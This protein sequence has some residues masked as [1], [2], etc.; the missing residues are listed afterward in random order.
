MVCRKGGGGNAQWG[1]TS[2]LLLEYRIQSI[3]FLGGT[4]R[5]CTEEVTFKPPLKNQWD[6]DKQIMQD[7]VSP[8][9]QKQAWLIP[10]GSEGQNQEKETEKPLAQVS[11]LGSQLIFISTWSK[12]HSWHFAE[13]DFE[14]GGH[15]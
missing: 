11:V 14:Q 10:G 8:G 4:D 6:F 7:T 9:R 2:K 5:G 13:G 12:V 1:C 15:L 3:S